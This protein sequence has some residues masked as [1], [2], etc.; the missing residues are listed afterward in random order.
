MKIKYEFVTG[1]TVEVEVDDNIGEVIVELERIEYNN[2]KKETRRHC[3]LSAMKY[4]GEWFKSDDNDPGADVNLDENGLK[5]DRLSR[6]LESLSKKQKDAYLAVYRE[7]YT[8]PEYAE[9]KGVTPWSVYRILR[10]AEEK[11]KI[12]Y[13]NVQ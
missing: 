1:E 10:R 4:E 5:D 9:E 12:F 6:A 13:E 8:V 2:E 7:G 3:I 11:I